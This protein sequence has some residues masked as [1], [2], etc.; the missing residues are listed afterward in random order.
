MDKQ[1]MQ[2]GRW[3]LGIAGQLAEAIGIRDAGAEKS[4]EDS[5]QF[6]LKVLRLVGESEGNA[7]KVHPFLAQHEGRLNEQLLETLPKVAARLLG[8]ESE[9]QKWLAA[10][11]L[12][13]F[14]NLIQQFP[15]GR[16]WLNLEL[17]IAASECALEVYT[18]AAFPEEWAMTQNNL[19]RAYSARIKGE[20]ADNLELAIAASERAL[21]VL[22]RAAFPEDWAGNQ[23]NLAI[24]YKNR[25]KGERA[26]NLEQA[27]A[28]Y[29]RALEVYTRAAFPEEWA[30][31]QNN[32]A[33][34]Y[35]ARIKGERADNLEL[36]IAAYERGLKVITHAAFPE[37]W[38]M[39]QNNLATAYNNR[40]KG[41]RADNLEL[42]IAACKRALKVITHAAFPEKWAMTQNNLARAYNARIKGERA[43]NLELAIAAYEHALKVRTRAAFP[44]KWAQTQNDLARAYSDRIKGERADNLEQAIA[45]YERALE[46]YTRAAFPEDWA[47]TQNNLATAYSARIKGE[48]A[49]N[50]E[51]AIAAYECALEVY[52]RAAFP[53]DWAMTQNNLAT[54]YGTR[55]K[56]ERADNLELAIA[57][58][59]RALEVYTRAAFPEDWAGNQ[60]N[61]ANAY[62]DRIKGE[63]ADN[64]EQ[65]IAAYER[66]LEVRTRAAFPKDCL[67][68]ARNLGNLHFEQQTWAKAA[69]AYTTALEAGE[70]LYQSAI[71]LDGK[72]AELAATNNLPRL[73]AYA[74]ARSG[75]LQ[76]AVLTLEQGRA[77]GLSETL[78]RDRANLTQLQQLAPALYTQYTDTTAQ[79]R[80]LE[81]QQRLRMTSDDRHSFI[82]ETL[83]TKALELRAS[84]MIIIEQIRQVTGYADFLTQPS[85]DD[86]RQALRPGIP[87]VYLITTSTG[88]L[89]LIFTQDGIGAL[90]LDDLTE[91]SLEELLYNWFDAYNE[92]QTNHQAWLDAIDQGTHQLWQPLMSPL[93][94]YLQLRHFQQATLIPTGFLSL[95]PL[96]TAWVEDST[97]PTGRRY[98]LDAIQ[99]TYVPNARSLAT[100][101]EITQR[102]FAD[103]I[104]AIDNPRNDL[105][106]STRE[107]TAAVATFP[108]PKVLQHEQA[109]I[110][111]VLAAL[112]HYNI[113][114]LSCHGTANPREPLTSG[115]AMS[116]GLLTLRDL[117][118][119]KLVENNQG[120]IRLAILSACETGLQGI[121]LADEAISLPTGLLQAGVAGVAASLWSVSDFSTM[122]LLSRF[123]TLWRN[124]HLDPSQALIT[125]QKWLRDA[126]PRDIVAHCETFIP[127]LASREGA[128][129]R[130]LLLDFSHPYYWAAFSYTGV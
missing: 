35:S 120:G 123:Y 117:L 51:L 71:L 93:I 95:L 5:E 39:I 42:A 26:D 38:A 113:L 46:V 104:L 12:V 130:S 111:A 73:A 8:G 125:A 11:L 98:A 129:Y 92:S 126:E 121:E 116:D 10:F 97:A 77:R 86:I 102:T 28:A 33:T 75:N 31:T 4:P 66:A 24:A 17:A 2:V 40:I 115:L 52:T 16:R 48:W 9:Q 87:L 61:L 109:A 105:P 43:D 58:S 62:S 49:D 82:P 41:E 108:Q 47:M 76:A 54:A 55:I 29:E 36:A 15:S 83:R 124:H 68:T 122:V 119:L 112:P 19:A 72:A 60:N 1:W 80:K 23:N 13:Q 45:A 69:S 110:S 74:L 91:N 127:E 79:L 18:H 63:R 20:R 30:M 14:G 85:F 25:I 6:L 22:T 50:L 88:S 99:F 70:I 78:D 32:L 100:A 90:W 89:A 107:V 65:A 53:K 59:E 34:A 21:E 7:Q 81:T 64:L 56:G 106:N 118:D 84:L 96:H 103:S 44:E 3:L 67:Q 128:L 114:H 27:I 57:A 94:D 101:E 37:K